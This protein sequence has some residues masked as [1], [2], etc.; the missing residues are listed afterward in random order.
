ML[1]QDLIEKIEQQTRDLVWWK[2]E[3]IARGEHLVNNPTKGERSWSVPRSTGKFLHD[4]VEKEK[5]KVILELGTSIGYSTVWIAS[6]ASEYG[7]HVYS[8]EKELHKCAIANE[9]IREAELERYV[10]ITHGSITEVLQDV[11]ALV[12]DQKI[13]F[14]FMDADRGHYHKYFEQLEPFLSESAVIIADNAV[15]M[16]VRMRLFL[17]ML[18]KKNWAYQIIEMDN[19]LL[20]AQK[21]TL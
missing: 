17:E 12:G 19:G 9:N 14:I 13:D 16:Q 10:T 20:F 18:A 2:P 1:S 11:P 7:G 21:N 15:N 5:P 4:F 8:I 6:A 3:Q